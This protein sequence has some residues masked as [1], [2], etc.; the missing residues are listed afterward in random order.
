MTGSFESLEVNNNETEIVDE[1][2]NWI[3]ADQYPDASL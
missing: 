3:T 1:N 2:G